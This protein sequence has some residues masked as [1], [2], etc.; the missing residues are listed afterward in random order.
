MKKTAAAL[1]ALLCA[2]PALADEMWSS[3]QGEIVY[4][5]D[6]GEIAV[7]SF[8]FAPGRAEMYVE[9][10]I[11]N[12]DRRGIHE[13]YWIAPGSDGNCSASLT[14]PDGIQST[15]WG[16][17][18]LRFDSRASPAGFVANMGEC[19]NA[20]DPVWQLRAYPY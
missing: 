2:G 3:D 18:T 6:V 1:L 7:F 8:P 4:E 15:H 14:G 11:G 20:P 17:F 10:L 16:R 13:G 19:F 5:R 12:F 9:N